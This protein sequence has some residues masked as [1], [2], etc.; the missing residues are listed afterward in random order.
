MA[1]ESTVVRDLVLLARDQ[2][3]NAQF[4]EA[5]ETL[6]QAVAAQGEHIDGLVEE[7]ALLAARIEDQRGFRTTLGKARSAVAT[8][9][10][11]M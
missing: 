9:A 7:A 1:I 6:A 2:I 8:I 11:L 4:A 5:T 10:Q 3:A